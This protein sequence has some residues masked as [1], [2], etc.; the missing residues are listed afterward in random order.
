[1]NH[2][3]LT[4]GDR[5]LGLG[6]G[7]I[8]SPTILG[9]SSTNN[10]RHIGTQ[11]CYTILKRFH[12]DSNIKIFNMDNQGHYFTPDHSKTYNLTYWDVFGGLCNFGEHALNLTR[13][14]ANL[15]PL[16]GEP[17]PDI[18]IPKEIDNEMK[19]FLSQFRGPIIV[20]APLMSYWNKM[21]PDHKQVSI[22][23]QMLKLG[24]TVIQIGGNNVSQNMIH[25]KAINLVNTTSIDQ[26]L[27]LIKH[28][29]VYF[30]GD[31]FC[32]HA[33]AFLKVPLIN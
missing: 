31:S 7:F 23:E 21:I 29:D 6:D 1:M 5:A 22:V 10:V 13:R 26:T 14:I 20:T 18:P 17:L 32:Q 24:A 2:T 27:A 33:A 8:L 16:H 15:K 28:C 12:N 4:I 9:L 3:I 30:G 19:S 11:Q 25:P